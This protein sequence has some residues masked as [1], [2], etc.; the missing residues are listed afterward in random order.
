MRETSRLTHDEAVRLDADA[1]VAL[2]RDL[3]R[4]RAE[5]VLARTM[6]EIALRLERLPEPHLSGEWQEVARRARALGAIAVQA[7]MTTLARVAADVASCAER[8][9]G[10][11]LSATLAR[12]DRIAYRSIV[13]LWDLQGTGG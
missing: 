6:E 1:L 7:G 10:P 12:L 8:G 9:D 2:M 3:G 4:Q 13:E 5:G 11:A